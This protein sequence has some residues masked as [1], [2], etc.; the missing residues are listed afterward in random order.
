MV[1]ALETQSTE[2]G[3]EQVAQKYSA[4]ILVARFDS[5]L[6]VNWD[7]RFMVALVPSRTWHVP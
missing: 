7:S 3:R 2:K 4:P 5:F 6:P 1:G